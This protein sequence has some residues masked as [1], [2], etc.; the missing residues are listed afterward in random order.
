MKKFEDKTAIIK[1]IDGEIALIRKKNRLL[2]LIPYGFMLML[3]L[4][5]L[6]L[7]VS[8]HMP[9]WIGWWQSKDKNNLQQ[10]CLYYQHNSR[11]GKVY[12]LVY[13]DK[14]GNQH[15]IVNN[16]RSL[17]PLSFPS[18]KTTAIKSCL[19]MLTSLAFMWIAILFMIL[20]T[21]VYFG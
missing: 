8:M 9:F 4:I 15:S 13:K 19:F 18:G 6:H 16:S 11:W 7:F 21:S 2:M 1:I 14:S 5:V 10:G 17:F 3:I 20:L 12:K